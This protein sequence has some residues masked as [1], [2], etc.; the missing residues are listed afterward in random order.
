MLVLD[1]P[2]PNAWLKLPAITLYKHDQLILESAVEWLN[3]NII[4]A[5]Q[6]LLKSLF[7]SIYGLMVPQLGDRKQMFIPIHPDLLL[8]QINIDKSHL[9]AIFNIDVGNHS[10]CCDAVL[11]Y[12]SGSP[13]QITRQTRQL[14]CDLI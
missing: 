12:D 7:P 5:A 11:I 10:H 4:H 3:C 1:S 13:A 2:D 6:V 8:H 14:S 9:V